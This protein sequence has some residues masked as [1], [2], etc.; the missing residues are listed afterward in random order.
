MKIVF[1]I[2]TAFGLCNSVS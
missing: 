2:D 1:G